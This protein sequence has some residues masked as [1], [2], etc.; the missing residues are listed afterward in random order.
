VVPSDG[1]VGLRFRSRDSDAL[2]AILEQVL[3]DDDAR[4]QMIG[5]ARE[6]VLR[7]DW[8]QV[9]RTT[10]ELYRELAAVTPVRV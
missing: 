7:F 4:A 1:S 3:T 8:G 6:H 5:E 9:A 2:E 10:H